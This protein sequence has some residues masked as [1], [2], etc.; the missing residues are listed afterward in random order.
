MAR[1]NNGYSETFYTYLTPENLK[2]VDERVKVKKLK[3]RS[4]FL[5]NLFDRERTK[6]QTKKKKA[7]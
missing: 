2:F 7:V 3:S 4:E 1:P 6:L 5:N